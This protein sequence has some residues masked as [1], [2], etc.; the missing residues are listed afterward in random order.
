MK[1]QKKLLLLVAVTMV[2]LVLL[3]TRTEAQ[4]PKPSAAQRYQVAIIKWDGPDRIQFITP[5]KCELVRVFKQGVE[6]P[7]GIRD[8]AFC[9]TWAANQ[10]AEEGWEPVNLNSTR[11]LMR[12]LV[13]SP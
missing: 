12:R 11:I 3:L 13:A 4:N 7:K 1:T 9:L 8:E 6:Q 5:E 2:G 10:L